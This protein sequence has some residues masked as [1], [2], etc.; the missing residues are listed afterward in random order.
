[1]YDEYNRRLIHVLLLAN[2][3][4]SVVLAA[5]RLGVTPAQLEKVAGRERPPLICE[6][7]QRVTMP[8]YSILHHLAIRRAAVLHD[9]GTC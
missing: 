3:L 7:E 8:V 2:G 1:M 9:L 6:R 5:T 4:I